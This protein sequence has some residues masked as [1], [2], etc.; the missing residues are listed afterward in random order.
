M[1]NLINIKCLDSENIIKQLDIRY[2]EDTIYTKIDNILIAVNPFKKINKQEDKPH[3]DFIADT[4][5][6]GIINHNKNQSV[7]ISGESGA[8]KTETTKILLNRLLDNKSNHLGEMIIASN[9]ILE[10]FGNASTIRNHNSSRFGKLITLIY[11]NKYQ[12][13]GAEIK[14][15]LLEKIRVT[16]KDLC[17]KNFHIFYLLN[18]IRDNNLSYSIFMSSILFSV[19]YLIK[20]IKTPILNSI[21]ILQENTDNGSVL[22]FDVTKYT[23]LFLVV[24][25]L[26]IF[27]INLISL[28]LFTF[29]TKNIKEFQEIQKNNIA[30]AIFT[31]VI[32]ISISIMLKDSLYFL[33]DTFVPYPDV[34]KFE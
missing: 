25:I 9:I 26:S 30:V 28:S 16:D 4:M 10:S 7:L 22:F 13:I 17:E 23:L 15:Y 31:G 32:V 3:P 19:A 11:D 14:T 18:N 24:V 8:G 34:P 6:N 5:M 1:D 2:S 12:I 21:R 27:I 29:M 33:L 20:D